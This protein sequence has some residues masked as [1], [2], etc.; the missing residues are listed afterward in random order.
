MFLGS[1]ICWW[2]CWDYYFITAVFWKCPTHRFENDFGCEKTFVTWL[3]AST[4]GMKSYPPVLDL[5]AGMGTKPSVYI[6]K[7]GLIC[8]VTSQTPFLVCSSE[9]CWKSSLQ[10]G[11]HSMEL[12]SFKNQ[13]M[14]PSNKRTFSARFPQN[15]KGFPNSPKE[16]MAWANKTSPSWSMAL[17]PDRNYLLQTHSTWAWPVISLWGATGKDSPSC[18]C[19]EQFLWAEN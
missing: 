4:Q 16:P 13:V 5:S 2:H 1:H 14:N 8:A 7:E 6:L 19:K 11:C 3:D 18:V 12:N 17:H 15:P 10:L 9:L